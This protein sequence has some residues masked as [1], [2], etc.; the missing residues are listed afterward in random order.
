MTPNSIVEQNHIPPGIGIDIV[1]LDR[2]KRAFQRKGFVRRVFTDSE[3]EA[4]ESKRDPLPSFAARFAVKEAF[5]K[6]LSDPGLK[7]VPWKQIET[8]SV[9]NIPAIR[10]SSSLQKRI[11]GR[12][13]Y[14]SL[15]HSSRMAAAVVLLIP[16][17]ATG[18]NQ[19][20]YSGARL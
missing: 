9:N 12:Q 14:L 11:S 18:H 2:F 4:C 7:S 13:I 19:N 17:S 5:C 8:S 15:T 3:I 6:A 16:V 20:R 1:D 10:L